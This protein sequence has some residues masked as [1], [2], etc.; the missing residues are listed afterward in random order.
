VRQSILIVEFVKMEVAKGKSVREAA[1][2]GAEIRMRPILIT[3]L[4]L[5]AGAWAIIQDPIFQ[6][7]AVSLF[8]GAGVATLMA[9]IVIPL[10]C[11]SLRKHF[12]LQEAESGEIELSGRY[13]EIEGVPGGRSRPGRAGT[14]LWLHLWSAL[15]S[16][17]IW[18]I[19]ALS[20]LLSALARLVPGRSAGGDGSEPSGPGAGPPPSGGTPSGAGP[21]SAGGLGGAAEAAPGAA[22]PA[23]ARRWEQSPAGQ[24]SSAVAPAGSSAAVQRDPAP[25]ARRPAA[26]K[27]AA[28][29][30]T[31][32]KT[33]AKKRVA[34]KKTAVAKKAVA[35]KMAAGQKAV[36][37]KT[38]IAKETAAPKQ[39]AAA[40]SA[41]TQQ[42]PA[43]QT[44]PNGE[45]P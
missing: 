24:Q 19:G 27:A 16:A 18:L 39:S 40:K 7:M 3:S 38:A 22:G 11:I 15:V 10:G 45:R 4:T 5:M 2:D 43:T 36:T 17:V 28:K 41:G 12:Y 8:F 14:P 31:P 25:A 1:V 6:G 20:T 13:A 44:P 26:K 32:R 33:A 21:G 35:K 29:K 23:A 37:K 42:R 34:T 9:V 30:A